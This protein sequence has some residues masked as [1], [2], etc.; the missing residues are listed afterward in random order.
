[1]YYV[2]L[3][4]SENNKLYVGSTNNLRRRLKEHR[5]GKVFSTRS[6]SDIQLIY[7]EAFK[8]EKDARLREKQLKHYGKAYQELKKRL[9]NSLKGAG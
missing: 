8:S 7:Y 9:K 4:K 2:Y 3:V 6:F 1:M 5:E